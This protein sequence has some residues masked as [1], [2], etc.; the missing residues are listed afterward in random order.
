M[1]HWPRWLVVAGVGLTACANHARRPADPGRGVAG[2]RMLTLE[3]TRV[4]SGPTA[5]YVT[6]YSAMSSLGQKAIVWVESPGGDEAGTLF[7]ETDSVKAM[8]LPDS[9]GSA[10]LDPETPPKVAFAPNG[11]LFVAYQISHKPGPK[12]DPVW[13]IRVIRSADNGRT[14][15]QPSNVA[16]DGFYGRYRNDHALHIARDGSLYTAWID[17]RDTARTVIYSAHSTDRGSTWSKN[18]PID[19]EESC[20]CCRMAIASGG[21]GQV[22]IAWRKVLPGGLRDIVVASSTDRG[23]TWSKPVL[24]Y[25]D[26]WKV[27]GCPDAGPS[28]LADSAG[29]LHLAWWTG[30]PGASGVKYVT[31]GDG[32]LTWGAPVPLRVAEASQP[33]HPSV[34]RG[35]DGALYVAWDDGTV[36]DAKIVMAVSHDDGATFEEPIDLSAPGVPARF[37]VVA[38]SGNH[39]VVAW[40]QADPGNKGKRQVVTRALSI[41]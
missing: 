31:S 13:S 27:D 32:G 20:A 40:H 25:A 37:P 24:A 21:D 6:T 7:V 38:T 8:P 5:A 26:N 39:L 22:F 1:I 34:A 2:N 18:T 12:L 35:A 17:L 15:S 19:L 10:G 36:R 23:A 4:V 33:S 30:K 41:Q 3:A 11:A 14:W 28:M 16:D 29:R 9:A